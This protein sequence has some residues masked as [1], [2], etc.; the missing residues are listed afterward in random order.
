MQHDW[1]AETL[2]IEAPARFTWSWAAV[3]EEE[4]ALDDAD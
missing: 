4:D 3:L 2:F 1:T